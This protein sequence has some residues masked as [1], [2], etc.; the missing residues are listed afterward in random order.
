M[1]NTTRKK[2]KNIESIKEL[3]LKRY[4]KLQMTD[5]EMADALKVVCRR[6]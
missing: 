4:N 3:V 5:K 6:C 2:I 1:Y